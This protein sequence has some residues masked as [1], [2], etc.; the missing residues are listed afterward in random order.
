MSIQEPFKD[1]QRLTEILFHLKE[2]SSKYYII[3]TLT[4]N[5]GA[6]LSD[7]VKIKVSD[8]AYSKQFT[9]PRN[10]ITY[11]FEDDFYNFLSAYI[12][13]LPPGSVYLFPSR[14]SFERPVSIPSLSLQ[15]K[16]L[17]EELGESCTFVRFQKTFALDYFIMHKDLAHTNLCTP[18]RDK[19]QIMNY[20]CLSE[21]EYEAYI[22]DLHMPIRHDDGALSLLA[23][24]LKDEIN[25]ILD[26]YIEHMESFSAN[27]AHETN[28]I[29]F[30]KKL[31]LLVEDFKKKQS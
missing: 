14:D 19:E 8:I 6:Y 24:S 16:K 27:P 10:H 25:T 29:L 26:E 4:L 21:R 30:I 20:L 18:G 2:R 22:S 5:T 3:V 12:N 28:A 13:S 7:L 9:N 1:R 15:L 17:A 31:S 11:V 23:A